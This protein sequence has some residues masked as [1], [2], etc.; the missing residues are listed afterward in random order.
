MTKAA[1]SDQIDKL[2]EKF[3][4]TLDGYESQPG[5]TRR[6]KINLRT[7][8]S[9]W[10]S[11]KEVNLDVPVRSAWVAIEHGWAEMIDNGYG[12]CSEDV[13]EALSILDGITV[14]QGN[15]LLRALSEQIAL[16]R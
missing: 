7:V 12:M 3:G 14:E 6:E 10:V 8:L 4:P 2:T 9:T 13:R 16:T 11:M 5:L 15:E 1:Q